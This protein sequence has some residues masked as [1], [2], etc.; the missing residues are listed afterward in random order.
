VQKGNWQVCKFIKEFTYEEAPI[1]VKEQ[2]KKCVLDLLGAILGGSQT[3]VAKLAKEFATTFWSG[4][5][6]TIIPGGEKSNSIGAT[7][8]NAF[9]ANAID[10][11]DGFRP[12]KGHPGALIIPAALAV[13]E[14]QGKSGKE[15]LEAIIVGYEVGTRAGIIWHDHY[16]VYH[17]SGSWGSVATAATTAKLLDLDEEQIYHA[18]GIAEYQAP[19][20]PMMRC[21]DFPAMVKDGIGWGSQVGV[22][23]ALM[24]KQGM[25]GTPSLFAYEQYNDLIKTLGEEYNMLRLYFKPHACCRWAQPAITAALKLTEEYKLTPDNI[26]KI[27]VYTFEESARLWTDHPGNTEEAQYNISY[28]IAAAIYDEEVGPK[29]VLDEKLGNPEILKL[30][31]KIE[32]I[33]DPDFDKNF[34]EVAMSEVK[35]IDNQGEVYSSG[36]MQAKGDWDNP[37]NAE[38]IKDKFFWL[39]EQVKSQSQAKEIFELVFKL[40]EITDLTEVFSLL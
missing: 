22:T 15:T 31:D 1:Q 30:M 34:P 23:S 12:V 18:L 40:D 20:N 3:K 16:P 27:E 32:L 13:A 4:E 33:A 36:E 28:P 14:W 17:A 38:E 8:A 2:A 6:A 9:T 29:Q 19:I 35:I 25:T 24:A 37:L 26:R 39:A 21:I 5:E 10:I 11:D 7:F